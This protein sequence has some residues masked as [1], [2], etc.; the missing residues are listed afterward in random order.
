MLEADPTAAYMHKAGPA[1]TTRTGSHVYG[2]RMDRARSPCSP[3]DSGA[4]YT[5]QV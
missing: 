4:T 1:T 2:W 5:I 3:S